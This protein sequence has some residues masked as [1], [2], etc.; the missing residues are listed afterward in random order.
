[1]KFLEEWAIGLAKEYEEL[2]TELV[3]ISI[4]ELNIK[5]SLRQ[6]E[7]TKRISVLAFMI[8]ALGVSTSQKG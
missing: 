1:M 8:K 5:N 7:I 6:N 4:G 2:C 3:E